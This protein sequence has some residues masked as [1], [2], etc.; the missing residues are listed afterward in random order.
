MILTNLIIML[1]AALVILI[2]P[3]VMPLMI[4]ISDGKGKAAITMTG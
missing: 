3:A 1:G 2:T 4:P